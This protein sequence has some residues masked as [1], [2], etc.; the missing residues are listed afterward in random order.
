MK[1]LTYLF[2]LLLSL[3]ISPTAF[4]Q[5]STGTWNNGHWVTAVGG[6]SHIFRVDN[7]SA[8]KFGRTNYPMYDSDISLSLMGNKRVGIHVSNP[9]HNFHVG[10]DMHFSNDKSIHNLDR[11]IGYNDLRFQATSSSGVNMFLKSNGYFGIGTTNPSQ[12]LDVNGAAVFN[13]DI[14]I[15]SGQGRGI[16]FW[17]SDSYTINMGNASEF[18][19]GPVQD[20]S[21]KMNMNN[22]SNRGW[23]WG[24]DGQTPIAAIATNGNMQIAGTF[25]ANRVTVNVGSFP[26]YVFED[27]YKLLS[28]K[29]VEAYI[30]Q[31]K[32]LPNIPAAQEIE[33]SGMDLA[34][35]NV[36]MMEK[37]EELTLHVIQLQKEIDQLKQKR[38]E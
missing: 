19:Y 35:I 36:L 14:S 4:G 27:G 31:H 32:H 13:G 9:S 3:S 34:K 1:R 8:I 25:T 21:I 20:Y 26:D 37:I 5:F 11:L 38:Q 12:R 22:D 10:T 24:V 18:K 33:Q 15:K 28:L 23:T 7:G 17:N 6:V 2:G 29:E 30:K 16:R